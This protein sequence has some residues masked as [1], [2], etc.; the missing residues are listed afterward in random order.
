MHALEAAAVGRDAL[1]QLGQ[2]V[3]ELEQ[4]LQPQLA[5]GVSEVVDDLLQLGAHARRPPYFSMG[6]RTA[7][8][9]STQEPS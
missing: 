2:P 7:L 8:P 5:L 3:G 6:T 4:Q 1:G 9:H